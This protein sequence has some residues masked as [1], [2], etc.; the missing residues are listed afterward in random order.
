MLT[1]STRTSGAGAGLKVAVLCSGRSPGLTHL[2]AS[3]KRDIDWN[4]VCC[5]TSEEAFEDE[6]S[7]RAARV[8]VLSH[9]MRRFYFERDAAVG[10]LSLRPAYD[11][12]TVRLLEPYAPDVVLL[13][14][15][16]LL[17]TAPMLEAFPTRIF[18][19]HHSD[20]LLRNGD[21]RPRYP[22]LRAVRDAILAGEPETRATVHVVTP[23]L[24]DGPPVLRSWP[25]PVP[26]ITHWA[27]DCGARDV[28]RAIVWAHQEWM[29]RSAFGPLLEQTLELVVNDAVEGTV[30]EVAA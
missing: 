30:R 17:L 5:L 25:F 28:L 22:G 9:S 14:G 16:L 6:P 13:C 29:L 8:P 1:R 10:D 4:I 7:V 11:A 23:R 19:V 21:G 24:D 3:R 27:R 12:E 18:N 20:L 26:Q 15:Y 2:L